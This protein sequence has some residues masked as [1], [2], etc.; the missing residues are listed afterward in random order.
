M[1]LTPEEQL[2]LEKIKSEK[3]KEIYLEL[4][5]FS[6]KLEN[7]KARQIQSGTKLSFRYFDNDETY[8][9]SFI[10][11][12]YHLLFYIKYQALQ[13]MPTI[14][15]E[16]EQYHIPFTYNPSG[17]MKIRIEDE[18]PLTFIKKLL[19]AYYAKQKR[20][21]HRPQRIKW[22]NHV[23]NLLNLE[24]VVK[25]FNEACSDFEQTIIAIQA[26][27][28]DEYFYS[29]EIQ[30]ALR[31]VILAYL[32]SIQDRITPED[33]SEIEGIGVLLE[34]PRLMKRYADPPL[35]EFEIDIH[36]LDTTIEHF[37]GP[38][39]RDY[40]P[41]IDEVYYVVSEIY[42]LILNYLPV[43]E[44]RLKN[45]FQWY[46]VESAFITHLGI[47]GFKCFD[48]QVIELALLTVLAGANGTG[49]ST[50]I[51][52]LLLL[53]QAYLDQHL[54]RGKLPLKEGGLV[55][56]GTAKDALYSGSQEESIM[57]SL[58]HRSFK[59]DDIVCRFE[60]PRH[61]PD[62]DTLPGKPVFMPL[63]SL[64]QKRFTYLNAERYGPQLDYPISK[65]PLEKMHVGF[66]GEYTA[67]CLAKFGD[68]DINN[69][70]LAYPD[71]D[72]LLLSHQTQVWMRQIVPNLSIK[73]T[74]FPATNRVQIGLK[75]HGELTD[76]LRPTNV[77]FGISY[78]LPI[79]VATLMAEPGTMLIVENPEAH[80]HPAAQ[81][82][83]GQFLARTAAAGV[84]VIVETHSDHI[85]NGIR[86]AARRQIIKAEYVSIQF[87]TQGEGEAAH[88]IVTPRLDDDGRIDIWPEGFFDQAELD[89]MEL[90]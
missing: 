41:P 10:V 35:D 24:E 45:T 78:T 54:A 50:V 69:T 62:Q 38:P 53:R 76:Y 72:D 33:K 67:E 11:N 5:D 32:N 17:Q 25:N 16:L 57:F 68:K 18:K 42:H 28:T 55:D 52:A 39:G 2:A 47:Q 44:D 79:V 61:H 12:Q 86:L 40:P 75:N 82:R 81:S 60:C 15:Q 14:E 43:E 85:L 1:E 6:K 9:F 19:T 89:L 36:D 34:L 65:Q 90:L 30:D 84:Q 37:E 8:P 88:Q 63:F 83:L 3:L 31:G 20:N 80:L 26:G 4:I 23:L 70:A 29:R 56:I 49:K 58:A 74:P 48:D 66:R 73:I 21:S 13:K 87:F 7:V 77:G 71:T 22:P 51:Q 59:A 64:F 46:G 27:N